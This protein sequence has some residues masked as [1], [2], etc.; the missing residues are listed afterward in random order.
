MAHFAKVLNGQVV[1]IIVAEQDFIDSGAL[2]DSSQW[3]EYKKDG[4]IRANSARMNQIYDSEN[5]V[6]YDTQPYA[7]WTLNET[8]WKW[9]PPIPK[10]TDGQHYKWH[11]QT[12]QDDNTQGWIV[13][14]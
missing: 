1:Q 4:S 5:D 13:F 8:I 7:S 2:G 10:P 3:V 9:E 11:E 6:F 12:Y 14:E